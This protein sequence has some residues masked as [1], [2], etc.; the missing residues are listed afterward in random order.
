MQKDEQLQATNQKAK[1]VAAKAVQAFQLTEEY[2]TILFNWY[3]KGFKLL[4]WYLVKHPSGVNL[5]DLNFEEVDKEMEADKVAQATAA[6]K[7][8]A[9]KDD[10]TDPTVLLMA[11]LEGTI[12][13][14][15]VLFSST[16]EFYSYIHI[17]IYIM[18]LFILPM[19]VVFPCCTSFLIFFCLPFAMRFT[20]FC[21]VWMIHIYVR[22]CIIC[23]ASPVA[24]ISATYLRQ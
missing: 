17:Y 23:F 18:C 7:E 19:M 22:G 2:N 4:R 9:P 8:N 11:Q 21:L 15:E 20:S 24:C 14:L 12:P 5:E 1:S 10:I 16:F 3:Y 6:P 13:Q